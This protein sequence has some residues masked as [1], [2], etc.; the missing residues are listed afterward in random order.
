MDTSILLI[1]EEYDTNKDGEFSLIECND[2]LGP[3]VME[4]VRFDP[5]KSEIFFQKDFARRSGGENTNKLA[6][7]VCGKFNKKKN[8]D[9]QDNVYKLSKKL[10]PQ[11]F[12]KPNESEIVNNSESTGQNDTEKKEMKDPPVFD[13]FN[14]PEL[15]K[16]NFDLNNQY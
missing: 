12:Q 14:R 13:Y 8:A 9:D 16:K 5:K 6:K 15:A 3:L 7:F 2:L 11:I 10:C 4:N 1:I